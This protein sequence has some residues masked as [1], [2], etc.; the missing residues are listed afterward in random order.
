MNKI[1]SL[2]IVAII[3]S[4]SCYA[5]EAGNNTI[6]FQLPKGFKNTSLAEYKTQ[7]KEHLSKPKEYLDRDQYYYNDKGI[8]MVVREMKPFKFDPSSLE[9][10]KQFF[11]GLFQKHFETKSNSSNFKDYSSVIESYNG[12]SFMVVKYTYD[13][14]CYTEIDSDLKQG[15]YAIIV[16]EYN[17]MMSEEVNS[18]V[19]SIKKTIRLK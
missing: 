10:R 3:I 1:I 19:E 2:F 17:K 7:I 4:F 15:R 18:I 6:S 11:D 8:G 9:A 13:E 16:L 14:D 5:Q 12:A